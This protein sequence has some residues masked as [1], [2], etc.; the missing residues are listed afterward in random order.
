[1]KNFRAPHFLGPWAYGN[2]PLSG[3]RLAKLLLKPLSDRCIR[4]KKDD[5]WDSPHS[6]NPV[7]CTKTSSYIMYNTRSAR[8]TFAG[9]KILPI[10]PNIEGARS[11]TSLG[12]FCF[13]CVLINKIPTS[14][15]F[16]HT[17]ELSSQSH[18]RAI[19]QSLL[20]GK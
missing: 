19:S 11:V 6:R 13:C 3:V 15:E 7:P 20:N 12:K 9:R 5:A 18:S 2:D 10:N 1:M 4:S 14:R 8:I 16:P 17:H